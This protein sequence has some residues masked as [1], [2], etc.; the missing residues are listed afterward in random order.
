[1]INEVMEAIHEIPRMLIDWERHNL[2]D[3]RLHLS[4]F[5]ASRWPG[6]P[7]LVSHFDKRLK[8]FGYEER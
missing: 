2:A 7:D 3:I 8:E 4:G 5:S 1:M 6:A